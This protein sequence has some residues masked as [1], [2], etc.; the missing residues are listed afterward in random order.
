[1]PSSL[2]DLTT[3]VDSIAR[4][5]DPE[6]MMQTIV[7]RLSELMDADVCSLYLCNPQQ[8]TLILAATQGLASNAVGQ[9]RLS[10]NEGLVGHI[11]ASLSTLNIA[12]AP[13]DD[14]FI[15]IPETHEQ[16]YRSFMGVPLIYLR[17]LIGV[18]VIQ[19]EDQNRFSDE[20]E[21]F[22]ITV[23]SQLAG[24]LHLLQ[25]SG[26]W[27]QQPETLPYKRFKGIKS[28]GGIGIGRLWV[29]DP[30]MSLDQ[31]TPG[32]NSNPV[33]EKAEFHEAIKWLAE[34]LES[35]SGK[36][37][38]H[39]PGDLNALFG[40]YL[41]MLKSPEL[42]KGVEAL[43][44]QGDSAPWALRQV[45]DQ[46]ASVFAESDDPYLKARSEDITNIGQRLL[47]ELLQHERQVIETPDEPLVLTGELVNITHL[48][49]FPLQRIH[50]IVCTSGSALSHTSILANA[51]GIPAV[52]GVEA[53]DPDRYRGQ[54]II[55]DGNR[56]EC[57]INPP[58]VL[59]REYRRMIADEKRFIQGLERLR[60]EP[61][62]SLD[63]FRVKLLTNT[64]LLADAT[65]GLE[66]GAEGVGLYR[67]EIPFMIHQSFP[68]EEEQL[69]IYQKVL[70]AYAPLPVSMRTLD[71]GGDKQLPY[72]A[73]HEENPYLGWRGIRFTLDNT[74]LLVT[75]IRA[76]LRAN[77]GNANL[78][79]L[80]PMVS[81]VDEVASFRGH[82][83]KAVKDL[84]KEGHAV[85]MPQIGMMIE[86]PSAMLLMPKLAPWVDY[87]SIGSN[88]LTQYLLA[89]DRNNPRVSALFDHLHP[90]IVHALNFIQQQC[91][92]LNLPVC[93]CGEMASDPVA[94][95][96]LMAMGYQ[97]ISLS[98]YN[99]PRIKLLIR[100][101]QR[102]ELV[103]LLLEAER[104][105]HEEEIRAL[106]KPIVDRVLKTQSA[107]QS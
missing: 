49:E 32:I 85:T 12:D 4:T 36:M 43:I 103:P 14:R 21:A 20:E 27:M 46:M 86:V 40:V 59:C 76:M 10:L 106:F 100:S 33:E 64:G 80:V 52:M 51:L 44:D 38:H 65:P 60:H 13:S 2:T 29:I 23:A 9:V 92:A 48:A 81:R 73:I 66:R 6:A 24:T 41:M 61:A 7:V 105:T 68:T 15:Y 83:E 89:V 90:A 87:V 98:A 82:V 77:L 69:R 45:I 78:Q 11:A 3:L 84:I 30:H 97:S 88:D 55:V 70:Q 71:I 26:S 54:R 22:L 1:M 101:V 17:Q 94:V 104:C 91:S 50:G 58:E 53:L 62:E 42:I 31:V 8:D 19:D 95:L 39:L 35:R 25:S 5:Q 96:V 75:Q 93:V 63:G 56:G 37:G 79:L 102:E 28:A 16:S 72:F 74:Q 107:D 67:S 47:N 34:D 18:L 57:I 99:I